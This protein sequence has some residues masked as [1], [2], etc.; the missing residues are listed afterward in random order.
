MWAKAVPNGTVLMAS[1]SSPA[2]FGLLI[3]QGLAPH[4]Y[5]L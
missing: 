1:G 2:F 3:L 5:S 4:Q